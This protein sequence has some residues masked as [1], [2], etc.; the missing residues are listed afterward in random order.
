M[1][2]GSLLFVYTELSDSGAYICQVQNEYVD[3][4]QPSSE[5]VVQVKGV[6]RS[7]IMWP[8]MHSI[9]IYG[10]YTPFYMITL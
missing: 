9:D 6:F 5:I 4:T 1:L 7:Y 3:E 8:Q 10:F 2:S